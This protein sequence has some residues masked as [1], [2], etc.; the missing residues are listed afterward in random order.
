M[1]SRPLT[2]VPSGTPVKVFLI[3]RLPTS[4]LYVF[5]RSISVSWPLTTVPVPL[6]V[7]LSA[8][9]SYPLIR[10]AAFVSSTLYT[11]PA[12]RSVP[13]T[14]SPFVKSAYVTIVS[15][16]SGSVILNSRPLTS[17]PSGT[18][19]KVFLIFRLPVSSTFLFVKSPNSKTESR[20]A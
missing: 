20:S 13:I 12:G 16:P 1:N 6:V 19:V 5:V 10:V 17:V 8:T 9:S 3:F 14:Y 2:S 11:A 18:P 4:W 7:E 15:C